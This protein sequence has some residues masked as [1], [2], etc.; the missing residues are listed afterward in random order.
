[1]EKIQS[2]SSYWVP[3]FNLDMGVFALAHSLWPSSHGELLFSEEKTK[4]LDLGRR[5]ICISRE[6]GRV[7]EGEIVL[8][9]YYIY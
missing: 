8:G 2:L 6:L 4:R 1:M 7:E 3:L 5:G 9:M